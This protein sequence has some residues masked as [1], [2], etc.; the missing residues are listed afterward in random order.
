[1]STSCSSR[2]IASLVCETSRRQEVQAHHSASRHH[3]NNR[4][5]IGAN[6]TAR[7]HLGLGMCQRARWEGRS[8]T[9]SI[10][11]RTRLA[12]R[13]RTLDDD[14]EE[15][16][17]SLP[18]LLELLKQKRNGL[19]SASGPGEVHIVGTGPGDP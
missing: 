3:R 19:P 10:E 15:N 2:C 16:A 5:E 4:R 13:C 8:G 1:M 9:N 18:E 7:K 12:A 14:V 6:L 17:P 11:S